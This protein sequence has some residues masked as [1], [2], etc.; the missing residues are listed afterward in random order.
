[1]LLLPLTAM[2]LLINLVP[3]GI[4][5]LLWYLD[6]QGESGRLQLF[7]ESQFSYFNLFIEL[8]KLKIIEF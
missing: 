2:G 7:K 8:L 3:N 4:A 5:S 1:M 6:K